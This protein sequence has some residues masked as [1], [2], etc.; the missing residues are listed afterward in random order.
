MKLKLI[1]ICLV[2]M[3]S[4]SLMACTSGQSASKSVEISCD[5]FYQNQHIAKQLEV[6]SGDSFTVLLCSN[7]TTGFKWSETAEIG[8]QSILQQDRHEFISPDS[9]GTVGA[10]GKEKWTFK[11]LKAGTSTIDIEY[12]RPWEGGEKSEWTFKLTVVVK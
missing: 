3:L 4:L 6:A 5:D 10:P 1:M 7:T 9:T 2:L 11:A 8:D 12:S